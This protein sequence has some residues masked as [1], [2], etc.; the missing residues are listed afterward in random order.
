MDNQ[1]QHLSFLEKIQR[2]PWIYFLLIMVVC[3]IGIA[4]LYSA[5]GG[6]MKPW[7]DSQLVFLALGVVV[8]VVVTFMPPLWLRILAW[9]MW[10]VTFLMLVLVLVIGVEGGNAVR[11][12]SLGPIRF[13]PSEIAK[14]TVVLFLAHVAQSLDWEES[15]RMQSWLLPLAAIFLLFL[16]TLI[17]P[18]MGTALLIFSTAIVI[19]FLAG[20]HWAW[21]AAGAVSAPFIAIVAWNFVFK[22]YQKQRVLTLLDPESDPLGAG[23]HIIQSKISFGSGGLM[24]KGFLQSTQG[25]LNFLPEKHTDFI[26]AVFGE[27]FGLQGEYLLILLYLLIILI[28]FVIAWRCRHQFGRIVALGAVTN[29]FFYIFI[30]MG[31][32]IGL[33]PVVGVPLPLISKGGTS[34]VIILFGFGL[35]MNS[36]I[37][38]DLVMK[39][40]LEY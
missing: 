13:Q 16:L 11:W 34:M 9:P 12:L 29:F 8:M 25:G 10:G 36:H 28:G 7:A 40:Q 23:Y 5:A 18:D 17:Q 31:M 14:Y 21:F 32:V 19:V 15:R 1:T 20:L 24:G 22:D 6:S 30:N 26:F 4:M 39:K 3:A 2:F 38:R 27:E 33:L 37:H 35:V